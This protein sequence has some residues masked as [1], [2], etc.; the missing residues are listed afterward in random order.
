[1]NASGIPERL[2]AVCEKITDLRAMLKGSDVTNTWSYPHPPIETLHD[3]D[4]NTDDPN[5]ICH[6]Q[7]FDFN[8]D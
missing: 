3:T 1:M 7:V 6:P 2:G 4:N 5:R 8:V